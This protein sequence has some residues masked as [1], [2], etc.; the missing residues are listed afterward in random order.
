MLQ[1]PRRDQQQQQQ[2][3]LICICVLSS[4]KKVA[5]IF[6]ASSIYICPYIM[7]QDLAPFLNQ[8]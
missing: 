3:Q 2:P 1:N 4:K 6:M 8:I 7:G 5:G